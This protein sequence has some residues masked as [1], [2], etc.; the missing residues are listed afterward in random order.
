MSLRE[1]AELCM[2][3]GEPCVLKDCKHHIN[4]EEEQN[5]SLIS[6]E[7]NGPM[8]LRQVGERMGV[9]YVRI[10]QIED[11]ALVKLNKKNATTDIF[12]DL[13]DFSTT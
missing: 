6:I 1:C 10:K 4:F 13:S 9:S 7:K 3:K 11:K 2:T 5:C 12:N 8:T